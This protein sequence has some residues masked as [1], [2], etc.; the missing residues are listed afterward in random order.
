[1]NACIDE[2]LGSG[3]KKNQTVK[4][5]LSVKKTT[6]TFALLRVFLIVCFFFIIVIFCIILQSIKRPK[7]LGNVTDHSGDLSP[8]DDQWSE[9]SF[10]LSGGWS[11]PVFIRAKDP[12]EEQ[13]KQY[14]KDCR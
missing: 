4:C 11:P 6:K 13:R 1:M 3:E 8:A 9:I 12:R 5:I 10:P 2:P 14:E 7:S